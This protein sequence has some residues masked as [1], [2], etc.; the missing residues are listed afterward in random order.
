PQGLPPLVDH[1]PCGA[2]SRAHPDETTN[3]EAP[4]LP[5]PQ[6]QSAQA[7]PDMRIE[8]ME[9]AHHGVS[10]AGTEEVQPSAEVRVERGDTVAKRLTPRARR[11]FAEFRVDAALR[12][13]RQEDF[14]RTVLR[15]APEAE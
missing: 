12:P 13:L 11:E 3:D 7:P 6:Q 2:G 4:A 14:N 15:R 10:A 8:G 5:L 9:G 1:S